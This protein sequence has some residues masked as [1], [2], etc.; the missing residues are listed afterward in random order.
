MQDEGHDA[1]DEPWQY[2]AAAGAATVSEEPF[3]RHH[4]SD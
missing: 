2:A 3:F 1:D 4:C